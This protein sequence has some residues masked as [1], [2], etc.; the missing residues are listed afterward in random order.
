MPGDPA[1]QLRALE[2]TDDEIAAVHDAYKSAMK[3]FCGQFRACGRPFLCHLV[4]TASILASCGASVTMIKAGLLHAAYTQGRFGGADGAG[5]TDKKRD[6]LRRAIG[7]DTETL[8]AGYA[9][10]PWNDKMVSKVVA[11]RDALPL[12]AAKMLLIRLANEL[13]EHRDLAILYSRKAHARMD[14]NL[15]RFIDLAEALGLP[16]LAATFA[17]VYGRFES[18][19]VPAALR[20]KKNSSYFVRPAGR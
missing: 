16:G 7:K 15:P 13:D 14:A 2:Y 12:D 1:H 8:I 17:T 3:I 20:S 5:V 4:G 6:H 10:F 11:I 9:A 18:A 19:S